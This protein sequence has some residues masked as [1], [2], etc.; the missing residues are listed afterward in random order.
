MGENYCIILCG[1]KGQR[2]W[3]VS[4][5]DYPK[6]FQ[7]LFGC[8]QSLLQMTFARYNRIFPAERIIVSTNEQY[9]DLVRKQLPDLPV[10]N[11]VVEPIRR[12]TA[13]AVV[14]AAQRVS[15][16]DPDACV[17]IVPADHFI[18]REDVFLECMENA[19]H[20]AAAV[21]D[22]LVVG[23][24]PSQPNTQ[25]GY[26]QV[27]ENKDALV[28]KV[29]SFV[30]KPERTFAEMFIQSNEFFWNS[31]IYVCHMPVLMHNISKLMPNVTDFPSMSNMS[32]DHAVFEV[33][34]DVSMLA[35]DCGWAD[36]GTWNA[37]FEQLPKDMEGNAMLA[38]HVV[39]SDCQ[40]NLIALPK[41]K[42][43]VLHD[44]HGYLIVE[45]DNVLM[46]CSRKDENSIRQLT[47]EVQLKFGDK[48]M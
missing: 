36:L 27:D 10:E 46:I 1:G 2:F 9:V 34:R 16:M 11:V 47:N 35:C 18:L 8:G 30:E 48:F 38:G 6:Q 13:P 33:V 22:I 20:C 31:S 24:K 15:R 41:D 43:A 44:L 28:R 21:Q 25:Y 26:I 37:L 39:M 17:A 7:D 14:M 29:K 42:L 23:M 3:P 5:E 19:L 45:S 4:H 32:I 12:N 40:D